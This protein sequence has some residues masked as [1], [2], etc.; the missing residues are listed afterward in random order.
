MTKTIL[1]TE[2]DVRDFV[3]G[4]TVLGTGGGGLEENGIKSLLSE[5][6]TGREIG[7]VDP[8]DIPDDAT[9]ACAFLMG[10]IAPHT[11]ETVDEMKTYNLTEDT[12]VYDEK[13]RLEQSITELE[14][15]TGKKI[16]VIVPIELGGANTPGCIAAAAK[17]NI[18]A[19]DGDYTGRAIPEIQQTTPCLMGKT[20]WPVSSVDEYGNICLIKTSINYR[21]V[22]KIGKKISEPA[23]GLTGDTGFIM[24]GKEM[25]E[26]VIKGDLSKCLKLGKMIREANENG[27]DPVETIIKELDAYLLT[28]GKLISKETE[29]KEGYYWGYHTIKGEGKFEGDSVKI[30]FKNENHACWRNDE[31]IATS[32]DSIFVVNAKT[33]MP[34]TNPKLEVGMDVAVI[35]LKALDL[36][37]TEKGVGILGPRY[38]GLD[39]DYIPIEERLKNK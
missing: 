36:F 25:K 33:G 11:K 6:E 5:L 14:E 26:V 18:L 31:V 16:D 12:A 8:E 22:E 23:Y 20:L 24:S 1:K 19:V 21:V 34:C 29:D 9:T 17:H 7:W 10:S 4:A 32:P 28:K 13:E 30:W 39:I 15:Y 3:R 37:R 2:K 38:F 27:N 35:G